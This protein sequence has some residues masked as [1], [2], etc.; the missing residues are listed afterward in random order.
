[1]SE[2]EIFIFLRY[3]KTKSGNTQNTLSLKCYAHR[4]FSLKATLKST[5]N[6]VCKPYT[7][8][9]GNLG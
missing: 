8:A 3:F 1:M 9:L 5:R 7:C 4:V 2:T 6:N